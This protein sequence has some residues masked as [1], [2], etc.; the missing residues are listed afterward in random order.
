M[1]YRQLPGTDMN[2]SAVTIGTWVMGGDVWGAA[3]DRQSIDTIKAA[4]ENGVNI[5]DTAA[6]YADGHAEQVTGMALKEIDSEVFV[7]TKGGLIKD[8]KGRINI[9]LSPEALKGDLARSLKRLDVETID[10]YQCHWPDKNTPIEETMEQL[11]HFQTE[12]KIRYIG[13]SNFTHEQIAEAQKVC[14]V[15]SLQS[16]YS[17]LDRKV[18]EAELEFCRENQV[19]FLCYGPLGG[20]ILTGKYKKQPQFSKGDVRSFFYK[21]Y[22][23]PMW[24]KVQKALD[25]T[26]E[27]IAPKGLE[28]NQASIAWLLAQ[29]GVTS[30]ITG[31]RTPEQAQANA[32]IAQINLSQEEVEAI[33]SLFEF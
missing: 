32:K 10:L 5:I 19:G 8:N 4:V 24:S 6:I 18:E 17:L 22:K 31:C 26:R 27:I 33:G 23:E 29:P 15:V 21:F 30:V 14:Q 1:I 12:G 7:A 2:I 3:D 9:D 20:G 16:Q 28:L 11:E 25:K 13:V